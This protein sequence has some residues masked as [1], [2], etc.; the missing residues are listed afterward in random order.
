VRL[1]VDIDELLALGQRW[2]ELG[3]SPP[4]TRDALAAALRSLPGALPGVAPLP[5]GATAPP[6]CHVLDAWS[7]AITDH[8]AALTRS[9]DAYRVADDRSR[10]ARTGSS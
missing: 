10:V 5:E 8:G 3:S 2:V 9:A 7:S 6:W 4:V 1:Q